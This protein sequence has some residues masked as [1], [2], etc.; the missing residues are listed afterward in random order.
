MEIRRLALA[1]SALVL[2]V[3]A[4]GGSS[5]DGEASA[6]Q[7]SA[8]TTVFGGKVS[9]GDAGAP[10]TPSKTLVFDTGPATSQG[11]P[12]GAFRDEISEGGS[13][14]AGTTIKVTYGWNRALIATGAVYFETPWKVTVAY[15]AT[16]D[17]VVQKDEVPMPVVD[18]ADPEATLELPA[19]AKEVGL[20]FHTVC[21]KTAADGTVTTLADHFDYADKTTDAPYTFALVSS[22]AAKNVVFDTGPATSQGVPSGAFRDEIVEGGSLA[23]GTRVALTYGE[24]RAA[25]VSQVAELPS[26]HHTTVSYLAAF[27]GAA[28]GDEVVMQDVESSSVST[29]QSWLSWVDIPTSASS[30]GL[31]FHVQVTTTAADGTTSVLADDYDYADKP[32]SAPYLFTLSGASKR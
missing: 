32:S 8:A 25:I 16:I 26:P 19:T 23:A 30:V 17:G 22:E 29:G 9:G 4:C 28:L 21:T 13:L 3:P 20:A 15:V 2:A 18:N 10:A 7:G 5:L 14:L 11:V 6:D 1:L 24:V 31:V 12:S 27:D